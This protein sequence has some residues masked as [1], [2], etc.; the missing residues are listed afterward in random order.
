MDED[1]FSCARALSRQRRPWRYLMDT[2]IISGTCDHSGCYQREDVGA[3]HF[4]HQ[5]CV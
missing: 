3:P 1:I 5:Q 4:T 2:C